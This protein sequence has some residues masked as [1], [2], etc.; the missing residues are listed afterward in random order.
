MTCAQVQAALKFLDAKLTVTAGP[1]APPPSRVALSTESKAIMLRVLAATAP[2]LPPEIATDVARLTAA[3]QN[4][5]PPSGLVSFTEDIEK[6]ANDLFQGVSRL[7][8]VK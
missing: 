3:A 6:E 4:P 8:T 1:E 5:L 2:S 7:L